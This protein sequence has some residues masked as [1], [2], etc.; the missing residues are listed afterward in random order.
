MTEERL[1]AQKPGTPFTPPVILLLGGTSE[2]APLAMGLAEAGFSVLVSTATDVPLDV[3][4][5]PMIR[6]RAGA[7]DEKSLEKIIVDER[8]EAV[9]DAAHPYAAAIHPV[10]KEVAA[11]MGLAYFRWM[12]PA[13]L[14]TAASV[15]SAVDHV[16]A[17]R[18]ACSFGRPVLLTTGS[19][20]IQ[21]YV[22]A[23]RYSGIRLVAR[24][25]ASAPSVEA[26]RAA[27]V[28]EENIVTGRG[29]FSFEDNVSTIRRFRIGV[30][31]TKDSGEAGGV[32]A[33][34]DAARS[35]GCEVVLVK[36]PQESPDAV[37]SDMADLIHA[38]SGDL[39]ASN[40]LR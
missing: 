5:H 34:L 10:A 4:E 7:L 15:H 11:R 27:G 39:L 40:S 37:F 23:A 25:L 31:V 14:G 29:P 13:A 18:V 19:R 2:S 32:P 20:N 30:I 26:A 6:R 35:E 21:P 1:H 38:V 28:S 24:V 17:A 8:V 22:R 36:R 16:E 3:G 12:R 9:V 33:K